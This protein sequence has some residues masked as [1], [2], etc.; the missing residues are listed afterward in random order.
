MIIEFISY[1][2]AQILVVV[3]NWILNDETS[4]VSIQNLSWCASWLTVIKIIFI[5]MH[6]ETYIL[7][8]TRDALNKQRLL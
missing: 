2:D 3:K 6:R 5:D 1:W 8:Q 7:I 4:I